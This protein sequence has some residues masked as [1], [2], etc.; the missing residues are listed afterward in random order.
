[1]KVFDVVKSLVLLLG[2]I[3]YLDWLIIVC[4][5]V[6]NNNS[7]VVSPNPQFQ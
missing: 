7:K 3:D 2:M 1:M 5:F 4:H 6:G